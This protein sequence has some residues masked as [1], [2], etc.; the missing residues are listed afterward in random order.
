[1]SVPI[2]AEQALEL[3]KT[4]VEDVEVVEANDSFNVDDVLSVIDEKRAPFILDKHRPEIAKQ[5]E[6][7]AEAR[8][9]NLFRR[10]LKR[11]T[12]YESKGDSK[13]EEDL[14]A[15][16]QTLKGGT[17]EER[18]KF[19]QEMQALEQTKDKEKE[20]AVSEWQQKYNALHSEISATGIKGHLREFLSDKK[21]EGNK[22]VWASDIFD[23][24][25]RKYHIVHDAQNKALSFFDKQNTTV[26]AKNKSGTQTFKLDEFVDE[27]LSA[28][29]A[30]VTDTRKKNPAEEMRKRQT[31]GLGSIGKPAK[32]AGSIDSLNEQLAQQFGQA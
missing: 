24:L 31:T 13:W 10:D 28:R 11:L 23:A 5:G 22:D 17:D 12:G 6:A 21:I 14:A 16:L 20:T 3:L 2:T 30:V 4:M 1:M 7:A 26:P 9:R 18:N 8:M 29:G 15:A 27:F 32:V 19:L 25:E